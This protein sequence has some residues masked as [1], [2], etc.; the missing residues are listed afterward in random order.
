M[1]QLR[2]ASLYLDGLNSATLALIPWAGLKHVKNDLEQRETVSNR[3]GA[4][5]DRVLWPC[6]QKKYNI[7]P[8]RLVFCFALSVSPLYLPPCASIGRMWA[9][10]GSRLGCTTHEIG[11]ILGQRA[12][13]AILGAHF[14]NATPLSLWF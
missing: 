2:L 5:A 10:F 4:E 12:Q 14:L 3:S 6:S 1:P 11:H 8:R 13:S 7:A 9:V